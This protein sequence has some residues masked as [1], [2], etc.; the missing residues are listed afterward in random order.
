MQHSSYS[1]RLGF[2][3]KNWAY[4]LVTDFFEL[5]IFVAVCG[6]FRL[7]LTWPVDQENACLSSALTLASPE[8]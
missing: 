5:G 1:V 7:C 3:W 2:D 6:P 4:G 8:H